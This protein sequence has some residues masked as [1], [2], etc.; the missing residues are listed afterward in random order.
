MIVIPTEYDNQWPRRASQ[1]RNWW[2]PLAESVWIS[3]CRPRRG[4]RGPCARASRVTWMWSVGVLEPVLPA[5][6]ARRR[7]HRCRRALWST[8]AR[9]RRNPAASAA[10]CCADAP[11]AGYGGVVHAAR[12]STEAHRIARPA[13]LPPAHSPR[14]DGAYGAEGPLSGQPGGNQGAIDDHERPATPRP[15]QRC[16]KAGCPG[17]HHR[18]D[19]THPRQQVVAETPNPAP[20]CSN[21]SPIFDTTS[22]INAT[23]AGDSRRHRDRTVARCVRI[24]WASMHRLASTRTGRQVEE[25]AEPLAVGR[26]S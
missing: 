17:R 24:T 12:Q 11:D 6:A 5:S 18:H 14:V 4:R 19:L 16:S 20:I 7:V 2:V 23:S 10:E 13:P 3:V 15:P 21:S 25:H 9:R 26:R 22:T 8:N 1:S